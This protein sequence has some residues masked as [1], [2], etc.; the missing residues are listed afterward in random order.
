[1]KGALGLLVISAVVWVFWMTYV[2]VKR[3]KDRD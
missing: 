2:I 3:T 1:M